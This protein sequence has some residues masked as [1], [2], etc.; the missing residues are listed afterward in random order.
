MESQN[1]NANQARVEFNIA[2]DVL[3]Q[4]NSCGL[5]EIRHLGCP[6]DAIIKVF[7]LVYILFGNDEPYSP[8][9]MRSMIGNSEFV[10]KIEIF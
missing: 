2:A 3:N 6:H 7:E 9:A 10:N 5:T 1:S 4:I 8:D